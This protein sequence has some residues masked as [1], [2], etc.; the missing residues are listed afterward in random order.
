MII[1]V[2]IIQIILKFIKLTHLKNDLLIQKKNHKVKLKCSI[3]F[4]KNYVGKKTKQL[5]KTLAIIY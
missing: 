4:D 2:M 1:Q 5:K 3:K